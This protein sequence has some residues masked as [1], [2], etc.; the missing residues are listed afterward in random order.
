VTPYTVLHSRSIEALRELAWRAPPGC[1]LELGVYQGGSA[2]HL[3]QIARTTGP[4]AV[5]VR[6]VR[7]HPARAARRRASRRRLRRYVARGGAARV[8]PD[9]HV[10]PGVFPDSLVTMPPI[11]LA[12]V[13][14]DQY[15]SVSAACRVCRR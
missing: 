2:W 1:F 14:A 4:R 15:E 10:V 5:S 6:H 12:H 13:D 9:A 8:I 11:A 3:A 7:R